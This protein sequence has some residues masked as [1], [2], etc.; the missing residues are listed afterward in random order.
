MGNG[1]CC[2][3]SDGGLA[4]AAALKYVHSVALDAAGNLYLADMAYN[5]RIRVV[6]TGT[7][8]ITI[9]GVTIQPSTIATVVGNGTEGY[10]GDG[11]APTAAEIN[12]PTAVALDHAGNIF[13]ADTGS[14]R[15]RLVNTGASAIT[16]AGVTIQ[17]NTIGTVAGVG[18]CC[19]SG[20]GKSSHG[21]PT[22]LSARDRY[23]SVWQLLYF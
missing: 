6:N 2:Y 22:L 19:Y 17:P 12:Y 16:V 13:I 20:D 8:S 4:T 1:A 5:N 10:G 3:N 14:Y 11:G 15:I 7:K 21:S 18:T 9:A 23:R